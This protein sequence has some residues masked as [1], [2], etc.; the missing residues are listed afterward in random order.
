MIKE[1][2][3]SRAGKDRREAA[4]SSPNSLADSGF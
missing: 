4:R 1:I 3:A 2:R